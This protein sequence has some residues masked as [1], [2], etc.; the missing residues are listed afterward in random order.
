MVCWM[1]R[2][3]SGMHGRSFPSALMYT[4][5]LAQPH[6]GRSIAS[7][8]LPNRFA[9]MLHVRLTSAHEIIACYLSV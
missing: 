3:D 5:F 8:W 9:G 4:T 6:N 1:E 2:P 7:F